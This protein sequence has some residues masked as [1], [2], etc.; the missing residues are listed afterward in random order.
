MADDEL[1]A[2]KASTVGDWSNLPVHIVIKILRHLGMTDAYKASLTCRAWFDAFR[3]PQIW[4][5]VEF[6]F[7]RGT[8]ED[9]RFLRALDEYGQHFRNVTLRIDQGDKENR[10]LGVHFL[11][12]LAQTRQ[13]QVRQ[14]KLDFVGTNPLFYGGQEFVDALRILFNTAAPNEA[15][16]KSKHEFEYVDLSRAPVMY[17]D[18]L[19]LSLSLNHFSSLR[20]LNIQTKQF[21]CKIHPECMLTVAEWCKKLIDLRVCHSSLSN[22]VLMAFA[23]QEGD[24]VPLKHLSILCRRQEKYFHH[25]LTELTWLGL[26]ASSPNLAVTLKFDTTCPL[27]KARE[28]MKPPIPVRHLFM[29]MYTNAH[30]IALATEYYHRTLNKLVVQARQ[31]P[32]LESALIDAAAW[33]RQLRSLHVMCLLEEVTVQEILHRRPELAA[34]KKNYTLKFQLEAHPWVTDEILDELPTYA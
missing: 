26:V 12:S 5:T 30:E 6:S 1:I 21:I 14:L 9:E 33:C 20:Y 17:T 7:C 27:E 28:I 32:L 24:R 16:Q 3:Q 11:T 2:T 19:F 10:R 15:G 31:S 23:S 25:D 4:R 8:P 13:G 22:E 18:E 29:E 34:N